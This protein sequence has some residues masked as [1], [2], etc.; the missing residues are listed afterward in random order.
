MDGIKAG[1]GVEERRKEHGDSRAQIGNIR[2]IFPNSRAVQSFSHH[3][4]SQLNRK[5]ADAAREEATQT[6]DFRVITLGRAF[7]T[8]GDKTPGL[9]STGLC[10]VW[11]VRWK[12]IGDTQQGVAQINR[13]MQAQAQPNLGIKM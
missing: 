10:S 5:W 2:R 8:C 11:V 1:E 4:V 6:A 7:S 12:P 9:N 3:Q 13:K